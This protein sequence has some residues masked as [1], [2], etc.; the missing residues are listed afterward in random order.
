VHEQSRSRGASGTG[1][2]GLPQVA[3]AKDVSRRKRWPTP[4]RT[5]SVEHGV[6]HQLDSVVVRE[7]VRL[8]IADVYLFRGQVGTVFVMT[9]NSSGAGGDDL[10]G[11]HSP[12]HY[13]F[14]IDVDGDALED[15]C[16]RVSFGPVNRKGR[17]AVE[18]RKLV[19]AEARER[20]AAGELLSWGGTD[21]TLKGSESVRLWAGR[22]ADTI[23]VEPTVLHA[24]CRAIRSGHKVDLTSWRPR[25]ARSAVARTAVYAIVLEL[26]DSAFAGLL[27]AQGEIGLWATTTLATDVG[28]WRPIN[29]MGQ[30]MVQA[31]FNPPDSERASEYSTSHPADDQSN[32]GELFAAL[33]A[34]VVAAHGAARDP[35]A[36]GESVAKMLL[37]D[38]LHYRVG[39]SANYGFAVRNGRDLTDNVP[40]VMFS[41]VTNRALSRGLEKGHAAGSQRE[42]FPYVPPLPRLSITRREARTT[43]RERAT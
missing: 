38:V 25:G 18:L 22:A 43:L 8:Q 14:R 7:D 35:V 15:L 29:R 1:T 41:L 19:G 2:A 30:P 24:M 20:T 40:E 4:A 10:G 5:V 39:S 11:F 3:N 26:P 16:Y 36:Y 34:R 12:A 9:V 33:V 31:L 6:S 17:Q 37:P 42:D 27:G 23:Y 28:G 32:Y 13:D 21:S